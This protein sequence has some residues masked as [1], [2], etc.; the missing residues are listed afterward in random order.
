[1]RISFQTDR[2]KE[3]EMVLG[4]LRTVNLVTRYFKVFGVLTIDH[5]FWGYSLQDVVVDGI[6]LAALCG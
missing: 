4:L 3:P 5:R 1:M 2:S 6:H